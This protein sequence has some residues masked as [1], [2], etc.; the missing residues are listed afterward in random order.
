MV[1]SSC[2]QSNGRKISENL[3]SSERPAMFNS[4]YA[5]FNADGHLTFFHDDRKNIFFQLRMLAGV[6]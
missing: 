6:L 5:I 2:Q 1:D 4:G 3:E